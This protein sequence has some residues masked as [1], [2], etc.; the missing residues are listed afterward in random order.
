MLRSQ[1]GNQVEVGRQYTV[2]IR[3]CCVEGEFTSTVSKIETD[4]EEA[5]FVDAV[6]FANGVR[7]TNMMGVSMCE[8]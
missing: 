6:S 7:L 8:K 4:P 5:D 2:V 3:D 1:E